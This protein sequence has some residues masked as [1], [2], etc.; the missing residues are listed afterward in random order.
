MVYAVAF[1]VHDQDGCVLGTFNFRMLPEVYEV[2]MR[3]SFTE[4][5]RKAMKNFGL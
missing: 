5:V 3:N 1:P 2:N 4:D